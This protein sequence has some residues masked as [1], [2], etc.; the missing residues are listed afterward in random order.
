MP[1]TPSATS[2]VPRLHARPKESLTTTPTSTPVSSRRRSRSRAAERVG[3]EREQDERVRALGVRGV[4][5]R[6][7]ADEAVRR[8][9]DHERRTGADDLALSRRMTSIRR[10]SSSPA[11]SRARSDGSTPSR[12]TTRPSTF[13]TAFCATTTTSPCSSPPARAAASARSAARSSPSSSS[14]IPRSGTTRSSSRHGRPVT[15]MPACPR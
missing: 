8:L 9:G 7:R 1:A 15:R 6:G 4:D 11:S 12:P 10:A 13:E 14:G 2:V 5:A 3:V